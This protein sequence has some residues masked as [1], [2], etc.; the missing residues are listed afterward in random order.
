M[1]TQ[2]TYPITLAGFA[3]SLIGSILFST[4]A[5]M[6][7]LAF[8]HEHVNAITLLCL[9]MLFS[10]PFYIVIGYLH[11]KKQ[12][13][14]TPLTTQQW[15]SVAMLGILGYYLSSLFDFVGLQY[16]SAGLERLILFLYPTFSVL[17][18]FVLYKNKLTLTQFIALLLTYSGIGI[19]YYGELQIDTQNS[20]FYFGSGMIL[21]CAITYSFYLVGTGRMVKTIGDTRYTIY[22]ML[23]ATAGVFLHYLF[24]QSFEKIQFTAPIITYSLLLAVVATVIPSFLLSNA[25]KRIGSNNVSIIASIGPVSTIVQAHLILGE[26]IFMAQIAGTLLVVLGVILIGWKSNQIEEIQ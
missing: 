13:N 1:T 6:V 20:H 18:N 24:T 14:Q 21:I 9:R 7:K 5:I 19:A 8:A 26:K 23:F 25:M 2:K 15:L 4:K 17:I 11:T 3:I 16:I 22:A 12:P 10:L